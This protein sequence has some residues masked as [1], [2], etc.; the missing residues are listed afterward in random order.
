MAQTLDDL[1]FTQ[2]DRTI[3]K[4]R[5]VMIYGPVNSHL[6]YDVNRQ[7]LALE[8]D[9]PN[10]PIYLLINSPGGEVTSGFSIYDTARFIKPEIITLV[11]GLAASMGSLIALCAKKENRLTFPNAK[12]LIHQPLIS[13]VIQGQASD[14]AIH[15]RDI[16]KT[17]EKINKLYAQETGKPLAVVTEATD[18][19]NWMDAEE[20]KEF[21][22]IS[23]IIQDR[24]ELK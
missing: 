8:A 20:A 10:K 3:F 6:A 13:G 2:I 21:G 22:L 24:S 9:D 5:M 19:D 17:K 23:R 1:F 14:L 11:T 12:F 7:L 15:A 16:V 18:R 4:N